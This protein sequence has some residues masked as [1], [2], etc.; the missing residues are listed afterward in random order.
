[1]TCQL[2]LITP[3]KF[4]LP[5]M[6]EAVR[7]AFDGGV[8]G[9]LQLRMKQAE[10]ADILRAGEALLQLCQAHNVTFIVNDRAD[11][12]LKIGADGVHLGEAKD[13][14]VAEA[15]AL[16]GEDKIIGYSCY[17]SRDRAMQAGEEGADYVAFG[18][19][20]DTQTKAPKGRPK[21]EILEW[22]STHSVLPCVAIGGIKVEN[23]TPLVKAGADFIAV[24]TGVWDYP[25]G[26]EAAVAAFNKLVAGHWL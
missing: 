16:L 21:P 3:E 6:L 2:Y 13:G 24:V 23:C 9:A 7:R 8:V 25:E 18:A 4:A 15:R 22:W 26:P 14:T 20:Y 19:F 1:M 12:T 17:D 5:A 10:D 11:L